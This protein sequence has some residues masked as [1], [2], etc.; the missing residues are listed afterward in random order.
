MGRLY[1]KGGLWCFWCPA[2]LELE[3]LLLMHLAHSK[4][5]KMN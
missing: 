2:K 5:V 4:P 1:P 3:P